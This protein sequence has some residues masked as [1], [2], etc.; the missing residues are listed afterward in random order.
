MDSSAHFTRAGRNIS[1]S[2]YVRAHH[3]QATRHQECGNA[4]NTHPAA[5]LFRD[6]LASLPK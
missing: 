3:A 4:G 2:F 6:Q 1:H 5:A